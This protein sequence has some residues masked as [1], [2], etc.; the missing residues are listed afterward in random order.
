MEVE[1]VVVVVVVVV[2][3]VVIFASTISTDSLPTTTPSATVNVTS[4]AVS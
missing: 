4:V 1:V 2:E 3:V